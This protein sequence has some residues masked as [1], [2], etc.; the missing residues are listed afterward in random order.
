VLDNRNV[1]GEGTYPNSMD[2]R[3]KPSPMP[4]LRVLDPTSPEAKKLLSQIDQKTMEPKRFAAVRKR[5][6]SAKPR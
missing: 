2:H 4:P 6:N 5:M 3:T 1:T